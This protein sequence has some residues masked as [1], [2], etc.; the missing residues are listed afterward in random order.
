[1]YKVVL[2]EDESTV[3]ESIRKS[4]EWETYGFVFA[5]E[6]ANGEQALEVVNH[7]RPEIVITDI[8]MP[9][10]DGIELSRML[11]NL[12]PKIRIII[13]SGYMEFQYAQDAIRFGVC[14]YLLKPVTPVK[15]ISILLGLKERLDEENREAFAVESMV[16][17]L[18]RYEEENRESGM[19]E[20]L[21][22][23]NVKNL[24]EGR[25]CETELINFLKQGTLEEAETFA[26]WYLKQ[27]QSG[28][29]SLV[30]ASWQAMQI[31][32]TCTQVVRELGGDSETV[33]KEFQNVD[34]FIRR[35]RKRAAMEEAT[36]RLLKT[37]IA[38]RLEMVNS[39]SQAV[40]T[41][42]EYIRTHLEDFDLTLNSMAAQVGLSSNYFGFVFK[43]KT[44][45][46]FIK[47]LTNVRMQRAKELLR[48][49][50]L[51]SAQIAD[52][53]GFSD[54]NYFSVVFK[55]TC[56]MTPREYRNR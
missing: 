51:T 28:Q 32:T 3:R 30:Y 5:G 14:E 20:V 34:D 18:K 24:E 49:T 50:D 47:Y 44:G 4:I 2:V 38:Y 21:T 6:A 37:V 41:A 15:L 8:R 36:G 25:R 43:Q 19:P 9:F 1:M 55:K 48:T 31:L 26:K 45:V 10:M 40:A 23:L 52:R 11:R 33:L 54:P 27:G 12:Y 13:L 46:N 7:V 35:F 29:E 53:V 22:E 17:K 16:Y 42:K 56:G 39:G